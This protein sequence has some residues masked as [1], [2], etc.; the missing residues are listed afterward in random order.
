[1]TST[2]WKYQLNSVGETI[3]TAP[4]PAAVRGVGPDVHN[5]GKEICVWLE[6]V[7]DWTTTT[8]RFHVF[9]TGAEISLDKPLKHIGIVFQEDM[10]FHVFEEL[11]R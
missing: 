11:M 3:V 2:I 7:P 5:G 4:K 8:R 9:G 6:V 1:M 10:V